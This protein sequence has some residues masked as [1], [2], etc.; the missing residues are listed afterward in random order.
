MYLNGFGSW[1]CIA[2]VQIPRDVPIFG[3]NE[4]KTDV[5]KHI[6]SESSSAENLTNLISKDE[7][8]ESYKATKTNQKEHCLFTTFCSTR[9]NPTEL[10]LSLNNI[11]TT[12]TFSIPHLI[13]PWIL[14]R[15]ILGKTYLVAIKIKS[16]YPTVCQIPN[17]VLLPL[18]PS[19]IL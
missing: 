7:N 5:N 14:K 15:K 3:N 17:K 13:T 18:L 10:I 19:Y 1:V 16:S 4:P 2:K 6:T 12:G 9:G 11:I 8:G